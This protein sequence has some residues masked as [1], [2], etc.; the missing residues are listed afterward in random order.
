VY[1]PQ[2]LAV[3]GRDAGDVVGGQLTYWPRAAKFNRDSDDSGAIGKVFA[4]PNQG[5]GSSC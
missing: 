2:Q 1:F 5:A 3:D 4:S